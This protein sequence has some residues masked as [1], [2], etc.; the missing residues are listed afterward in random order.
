M[1]S[2]LIP[3][4]IIIIIIIIINIINIII[5]I[6][7]WN[8]ATE[9]QAID[10]VHRLGQTESVFIHRFI[11]KD[12]VEEKLLL[13]QDKKRLLIS[14]ATNDNSNS[15]TNTNS[16]KLTLDDLKTFFQ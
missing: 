2:F 6:I 3:G 11:I 4:I 10:R 9:D 7:R 12:S 15:N 1:L 13:L 16:I 5:I 14:S 8:P